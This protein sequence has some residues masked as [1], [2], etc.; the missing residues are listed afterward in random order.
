MIIQIRLGIAQYLKIVH[1]STALEFD[2]D[3]EK[4]EEEEEEGESIGVQSS[5]HW[6]L[7]TGSN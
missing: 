3:N 6:I 7:S 5:G 1:V 4:K 2:I